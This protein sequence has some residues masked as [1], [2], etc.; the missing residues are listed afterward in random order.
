MTISNGEWGYLE[1]ARAGSLYG[2][3]PKQFLSRKVIGT[4]AIPFGRAVFGYEGDDQFVCL[5][6]VDTN[7]LTLS[8]VLVTGNVLTV[9]VNGTAY[10]ETFATDSAT[11]LA[12]LVAQLNAVTGILASLNSLVITITTKGAA[13]TTTGAITLGATQAT[14]T[15]G[16]AAISGSL[17]FLGV[18]TSLQKQT[19][20]PTYA[21]AS[22]A[23]GAT[24]N[25]P[26][27]VVSILNLGAIVVETD[28]TTIL[29]QT[30]CNILKTVAG[31]GKFTAFA[32]SSGNQLVHAH[33]IEDPSV[34]NLYVVQLEGGLTAI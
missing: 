6:K 3:G 31:V 7:T 18:S 14:V 34:T 8:D 27:E 12:A 10:A 25:D 5:P 22:F 16:T 29:A 21:D 26:G 13:I 15:P 30:Q 4:D 28:G 33:Y 17:A 23:P 1:R 11:T 19:N 32:T 2:T 9:T 20:A 24:E